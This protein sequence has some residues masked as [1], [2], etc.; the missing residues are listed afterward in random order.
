MIATDINVAT[1]MVLAGG[2]FLAVDY[3]GLADGQ[4]TAQI[5]GVN[6]ITKRLEVFA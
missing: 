2:R 4:G 6:E 5:G 1:K 3:A